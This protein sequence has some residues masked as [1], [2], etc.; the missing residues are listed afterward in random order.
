MFGQHP[1]CSKINAVLC[2]EYGSS[3]STIAIIFDWLLH[4]V[5]CIYTVSFTYKFSYSS[6]MLT[7]SKLPF[8]SRRLQ[9]RLIHV[10]ASMFSS[11]I[12]FPL[13]RQK[14]FF[15]DHK[16]KQTTFPC[17]LS[18]GYPPPSEEQIPSLFWPQSP[19]GQP[20][21]TSLISQ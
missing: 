18:L 12:Q 4:F 11:L 9:S 21:A 17:R 10:C 13:V 2:F 19:H 1:R 20:L 5:N 15:M 14:M 16:S 3:T 6:L 7:R 8:P